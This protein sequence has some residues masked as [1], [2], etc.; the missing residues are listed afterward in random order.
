[1]KEAVIA[2]ITRL[3]GDVL[4]VLHRTGFWSL[5][6]G[7]VE[8][9][10]PLPVALRRELTEECNADV[11]VGGCLYSASTFVPDDPT[12]VHVFAAYL[13]AAP[14]PRETNLAVGWMSRD[15]LRSQPNAAGAWLDA[16]FRSLDERGVIVE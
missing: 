14:G 13:C 2:H 1:M 16:F 6:G 3:N 10:E 7:K 9:G 8:E 11:D 15:F 4:A 5:P 12:Y